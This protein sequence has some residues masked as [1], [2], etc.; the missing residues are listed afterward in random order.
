MV[1][2]AIALTSLAVLLVFVLCVPLTITLH[3]RIYGRPELVL[4]VSWFFGI[5][6][7]ELSRARKAPGD[8]KKADPGQADG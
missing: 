3:T 2:V 6:N 1:W 7:K 8:K 4:H 5:L